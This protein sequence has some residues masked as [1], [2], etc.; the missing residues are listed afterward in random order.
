MPLPV[1]T[2]TITVLRA[3]PE[4][5]WAEPYE[6]PPAR[7]AVAQGVRAVIDPPAGREA[8]REVTE[9]GEQTRTYL[10]LICDPC[11]INHNDQVTDERT[12]A[13]YLVTWILR[14]PGPGTT[15]DDISHIEGGLVIIEGLVSSP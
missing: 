13:T 8:G 2:T 12:G 4:S 9:G 5:V 1:H 7:T 3:G 10:R 15:G 6:G 11:D 14:F